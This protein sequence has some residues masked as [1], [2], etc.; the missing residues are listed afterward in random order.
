[1][2]RDRLS[3][4][5][6]TDALYRWYIRTNRGEICSVCAKDDTSDDCHFLFCHFLSVLLYKEHA[7]FHE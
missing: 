7:F 6:A 2:V 4:E 5:E 3:K 1:M